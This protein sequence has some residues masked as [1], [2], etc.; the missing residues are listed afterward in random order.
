MPASHWRRRG[1]ATLW[2]YALA[3]ADQSDDFDREVHLARWVQHAGAMPEAHARACAALGAELRRRDRVAWHEP[4]DHTHET[5]AA[6]RAEGIRLGCVSNSDGTVERELEI[7]GLAQY[8]EVVIDSDV[9]GI[10]KPD[11]RIFT[12][13]LDRMSGLRPDECVYVG[14]TLHYDVRPAARAGL[15]P[16]HLDRFGVYSVPTPHGVRIRQL[17]ELLAVAIPDAQSSQGQPTC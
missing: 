15:F 14:D 16:C 3:D 6:L 5:L 17:P 12:L 2:T 8:F 13:A 10:E 1:V 9:V 7:L 11:P 4:I